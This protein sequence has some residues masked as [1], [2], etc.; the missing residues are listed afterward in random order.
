MH[1][2]TVQAV[3]GARPSSAARRP[4]WSRAIRSAGKLTLQSK[5]PSP[6]YLRRQSLTRLLTLYRILFEFAA[7]LYR[8]ACLEGPDKRRPANHATG[9]EYTLVQHALHIPHGQPPQ[10]VHPNELALPLQPPPPQPPL[11]QVRNGLPMRPAQPVAYMQQQQAP[12]QVNPSS[13]TSLLDQVWS[14]LPEIEPLQPVYQAQQAPHWQLVCQDQ[15]MGDAQ[16]MF[17]GQQFQPD[18]QQVPLASQQMSRAGLSQWIPPGPQHS[19][20]V[21]NNLPAAMP[22]DPIPLWPSYTS[23]DAV[24][25]VQ[26]H[27]GSLQSFRK[28]LTVP[29]QPIYP[30]KPMLQQPVMQQPIDQLE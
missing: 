26:E 6:R 28:D 18:M 11:P 17:L 21:A 8:I 9:V 16:N 23:Q 24:G 19:Q 29:A 10:Q 30:Q 7:L 3:V 22:P 27:M 13:W 25:D 12:L 2:W 14:A 1:C 20:I 15:Q 5:L 4:T